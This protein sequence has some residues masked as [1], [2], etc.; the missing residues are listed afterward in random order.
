LINLYLIRHGRQ[1]SKLCN[2]D[3]ELSSEGIT[4]AELLRERLRHYEI[5]ALYS[6]TLIRARQTAEIINKALWLPIIIREEIKEISFG[7]MEGKSDEYNDEYFGASKAEQLKLLEDIPYPGGENGE[8]VCT[9]A[10]PVIREMIESGKKNIAVVTHGGT[11][12][13]LLAELFGSNQA[14]RFLFATSLE[15]TSITQLVY[16]SKLERFYL[17]RFNDS[18]HLEGHPDLQ[19]RSFK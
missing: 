9:R 4:Q 17:E 16:H 1:N 15:N 18:A 19:R 7:F 12:R 5:D 3:V 8:A 11:I 10:M 2:V 13:A 6:S 14:K